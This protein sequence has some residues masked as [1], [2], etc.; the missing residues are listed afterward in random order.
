[1]ALSVKHAFTSA[2]ADSG[3][4]SLVQP[5]NWNAEHTLIAT[6]GK[7]LGASGSTTV[8]E[9]T[10]G[11]G[12]SL[13]AG[14]LSVGDLSGTYQPLDSD[15][16]T[17]AGLT[18]TSNNF[19]QSASSAWASRTPTQVTATLDAM[20]GDSGSGGTKGLVPAPAAGDAAASKFLK[21]DATWAAV[22]A[23]PGGSDTQVQFNDGGSTFGGDA[24]LTFNK[25]SGVLSLVTDAQG[26]LTF[27]ASS[28]VLVGRGA[29]ANLRLG[30][31][32]AASPTAQTLS[33]QNVATGT[34]N[35]AGADFTIS[36][37]QGTGTGAGGNIVFKTA[38][39]GGSGSSQN[40]LSTALTVAST[41][42]TQ[43]TALTTAA[44]PGLSMGTYNTGLY[45]VFS[46]GIMGFAVNGLALGYWSSNGFSVTNSGGI[47]V[48]HNSGAFAL[49][50][51]ADVLLRRKAAA[52]LQL[53]SA[54]AASPVAQTLSVQ[55]VVAGTTNTAGSDF[56]IS[57][58]QGTGTGAGG[59]IYFKV[60]TAG[61]T[62]S[63]QNALDKYW[64]VAGN[65]VSGSATG[66]LLTNLS[67][68]ASGTVV[69]GVNNG[70]SASGFGIRQNDVNVSLG[71]TGVCRI[72]ASLGSSIGVVLG[73]AGLL[74]WG[75]AAGT[76]D[77]SAF[78]TCFRRAG[79]ASIALGNVDAAS[80]VA[81]TLS[82]QS[83]VA[84][85][86][87]T[88]GVD[89]TFKG[90]AGTGT[91]AGGKIIFQTAP[92]GGSGTSQNALTTT[93]TLDSNN[94][95]VCHNAA[96]S[97]SAND[98]F[99]YIPT[100]AGTPTGTPTTYT[101]RVAMIFDTTNSKLYIYSGSWKGGTAPGAW[102]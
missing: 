62:G 2:I 98:G 61:T 24:Q 84:G 83:V 10:V 74:G 48:E 1:M 44:A 50:S 34:S 9:I 28:D 64:Y 95:V 11:T 89:W 76:H 12:L 93:L 51:S 91:G 41:R 13:A 53:G 99:L 7:L 5:S 36:G 67:T 96:T 59:A 26:L 6:D 78:D 16:T 66:S 102:S 29:A 94:N 19:I 90:S 31:A 49:G 87:N 37:S 52:N 88:A 40:A 3:N 79:A 27:G 43:F 77:A 97:T 32:D 80:P 81:Q 30:A 73:S 56:T 38:A 92:L 57:G 39:A 15:L 14:T 75:S 22:S 82:V 100:C 20:V 45:D 47:T 23:S 46:N 69:L 101:G 86:S 58:S 42:Q 18:A 55:N 54:D 21:A 35:T 4:S 68:I 71:G 25:T 63:S 85:T 65:P 60:A 8:G 17:I 72:T 33:V 70:S